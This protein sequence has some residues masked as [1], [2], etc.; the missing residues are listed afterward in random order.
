MIELLRAFA[1]FAENLASV[2]G[3]HMKA[4]NHP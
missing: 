3:T 4:H 1:A 2:S